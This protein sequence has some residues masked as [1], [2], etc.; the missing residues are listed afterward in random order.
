MSKEKHICTKKH[1]YT[2][3]HE[4]PNGATHPE[5]KFLFSENDFSTGLE[6]DHYECLVCGLHFSVEVAQ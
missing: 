2:S 6:Y 1:P 4:Y 5:A 3:R